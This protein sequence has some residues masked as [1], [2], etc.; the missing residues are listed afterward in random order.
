[1]YTWPLGRLA[2]N[3]QEIPSIS[4]INLPQFLPKYKEDDQ[5]AIPV[6]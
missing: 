6:Q 1:M 3:D 5:Y 2:F 4:I